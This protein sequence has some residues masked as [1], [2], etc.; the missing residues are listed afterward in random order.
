MDKEV[1]A[2]FWDMIL[3]HNVWISIEIELW[4]KVAKFGDQYWKKYYTYPPTPLEGISYMPLPSKS[5][6]GF[7]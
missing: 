6:I 4:F 2:I 5:I 3:Q 1:S 7:T